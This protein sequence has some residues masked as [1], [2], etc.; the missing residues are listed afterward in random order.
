MFTVYHRIEQIIGGL[1]LVSIPLLFL[2]DRLQWSLAS[3]RMFQFSGILLL[4]QGLA[5]DLVLLTFYRHRLLRQSEA[6]KGPWICVE[7]TIGAGLIAMYL[8]LDFMGVTGTTTLSAPMGATLAA[9]IWWFGFLTRDHILELKKE[10]NHLNLV[11][12]FRSAPPSTNDTQ[13]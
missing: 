2:G 10:P 1:L 9:G 3:I 6:K 13:G 7:S 12:G 4:A 8:L 11:F 5:R